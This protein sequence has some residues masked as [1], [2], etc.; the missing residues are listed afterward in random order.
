M[1]RVTRLGRAAGCPPGTVT[2]S[3][4]SHRTA[5][6]AAAPEQAAGV[7]V[8]LAAR[9]PEPASTRSADEIIH[10][11]YLTHALALIRLAR[12]L[13]RDQSSAEDAVQEAFLGL[14][15]ALPRL[16]DHAEL[17]PY[18]RASVLNRCRT[19]L[20]GRRRAAERPVQHEPPASSAEY[21]AM[22]GEDRKAVLDAVGRLPRRAREVLV[23]RYYLELTDAQISSALGISRGTVSSTASRALGVLGITLKEHL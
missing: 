22:I 14:Y 17:L 18:L 20:R 12:L 4:A 19:E 21:T 8:S 5:Y 15:R 7:G 16:S 11:L 6:S 10:D 23:L 13:V 2:A 9:D 3:V 1:K